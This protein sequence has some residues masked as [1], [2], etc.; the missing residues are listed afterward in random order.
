MGHLGG[1]AVPAEAC[2]RRGVLKRKTHP[3]PQP[4][5]ATLC[6]H[7]SRRL[8]SGL[9]YGIIFGGHLAFWLCGHQAATSVAIWHSGCGHMATRGWGFMCFFS[10]KDAPPPL[11]PYDHSRMHSLAWYSR[12]LWWCGP[13]VFS[14]LGEFWGT[15]RGVGVGV[16]FSAPR[17][18]SSQGTPL[19]PPTLSG[20]AA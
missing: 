17:C 10:T 18:P 16:S 19:T 5:A 7:G 2:P 6:H 9:P 14:T 15:R 1:A 11:W 8:G 4:P 20:D 12:P 3:H 13:Y